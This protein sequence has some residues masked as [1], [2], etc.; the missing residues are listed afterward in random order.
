MLID[1]YETVYKIRSTLLAHKNSPRILQV[2]SAAKQVTC[3]YQLLHNYF[4]TL[5]RLF[6]SLFYK[7]NIIKIKMKHR[8]FQH[9][10][11]MYRPV[12]LRKVLMEPGRSQ[13]PR[14]S[15]SER[16]MSS[17]REVTVAGRCRC[18]CPQPLQKTTTRKRLQRR[19]PLEIVVCTSQVRGMSLFSPF[20]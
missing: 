3:S 4:Y 14:G 12:F 17:S 18:R 9:I 7:D 13:A 2:Q 16:I 19:T 5:K 20:L 11:F 10:V 6:W 8:C 15:R 1:V